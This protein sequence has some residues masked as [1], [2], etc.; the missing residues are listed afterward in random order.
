MLERMKF[1]LM[2]RSR[3]KKYN[4]LLNFANLSLNSLILDAGVAD[5]E[6]SPFDSY[7]EK[8]Y[9]YSKNISALSIYPLNKFKQRYPEINVVTYEGYR[10][11]YDD[12]QFDLAVS[13]AVIEHVGG[14]DRQLKFITEL[15]RVSEKFYF[16]TPA[17]EFPVEMHTNIP[18]LHWLPKKLFDKI[19]TMI[20]KGW[21]TGPYMNLLTKNELRNLLD[22]ADITSYEIRVHRFGPFPLHYIVTG[23]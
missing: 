15:C 8:K 10:F 11:P 6:Y 14:H 23:Y 7:F 4:D 16:T 18:I 2:G 9:P 22:K 20:G 21:A 1:F 5:E 19:L 17:R 12:K 3:E 13:N